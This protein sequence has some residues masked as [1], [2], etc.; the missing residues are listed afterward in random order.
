VSLHTPYTRQTHHLIDL[1]AL[2]RMKP[3]AALINTSRGA[4]VDQAALR[5]ALE[6]GLIAGAALDVTDPEPM[7]DDDPLLS[8]HNVII[9]PHIGSATRE[10]RARM[11]LMAAD[12]LIA[13]VSGQPLPNPVTA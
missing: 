5:E 13:G 9:V 2:A 7:R 4:V 6:R 8:L 12:N 11:A 1:E 3:S 10:T